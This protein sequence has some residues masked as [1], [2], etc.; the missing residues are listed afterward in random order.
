[1]ILPLTLEKTLSNARKVE[2]RFIVF[3]FNLG[4]SADMQMVTKLLY[5]SV[6]TKHIAALQP[7]AT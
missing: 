1:M 5:F 2:V 4:V 7:V 6:H 3:F